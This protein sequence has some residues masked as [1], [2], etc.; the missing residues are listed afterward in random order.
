MFQDIVDVRQIRFPLPVLSQ[1][2]ASAPAILG[3]TLEPLEILRCE[4][5][6]QDPPSLRV[7]LRPGAGAEPVSQILHAAALAA[8]LIAYCKVIGLPISRSA[9]KRLILGRDWITL[10][11]EL[12]CPVP[13]PG[14]PGNLPPSLAPSGVASSDV[15]VGKMV[16]T[17][18]IEPRTY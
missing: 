13:S 10:E 3:L 1:A 6:S 18:G 7:V 16:P 12:R 15:E 9:D 17:R 2:L 14:R 4:P 11:T 5:L 8:A